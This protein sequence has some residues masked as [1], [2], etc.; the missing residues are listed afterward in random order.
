MSQ[1][2]DIQR[3]IQIKGVIP[4]Q[5]PFPKGFFEAL[6][7]LRQFLRKFPESGLVTSLDSTTYRGK[8][9][10]TPVLYSIL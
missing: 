2:S 5:K 7:D 4:P 10:V 6:E 8:D 1:N 3:N 9:G